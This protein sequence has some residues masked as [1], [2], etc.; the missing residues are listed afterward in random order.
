MWCPTLSPTAPR[1]T[2]SGGIL[3][4]NSG[5]GRGGLS[6]LPRGSGVSADRR[7]DV[8]L[9]GKHFV[10]HLH[11]APIGRDRGLGQDRLPPLGLP[12]LRGRLD[13]SFFY[14]SLP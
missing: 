11:G 2:V 8:A 3:L 9:K 1:N 7:Q 5:M 14:C 13:P 4:T 12:L 10:H 6:L